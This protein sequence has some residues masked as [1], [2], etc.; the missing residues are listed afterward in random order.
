MFS[1]WGKVIFHHKLSS[2]STIFAVSIT[3]AIIIVLSQM[4]SGLLGSYEEIRLES[5][6]YD[7]AYSDLTGS[8][9]SI[10]REAVSSDAVEVRSMVLENRVGTYWDDLGLEVEWLEVEGDLDT[11]FGTSLVSGRMPQ[12]SDEVCITQTYLDQTGLDVRVGDVITASVFTD[13]R[14]TIEKQATVVGILDRYVSLSSS[15]CTLSA[16]ASVSSSAPSPA[17]SSSAASSSASAS[18]PTDKSNRTF[19]AYFLASQNAADYAD[20]DAAFNRMNY[21]LTGVTDFRALSSI[22]ITYTSTNTAGAQFFTKEESRMMLIPAILIISALFIIISVLFV[23]ILVGVMLT[24]RKRDYGIL[25]ALGLSRKRMKSLLLFEAAIFTAGSA[26]IGLPLGDGLL[27]LSYNILRRLTVTG[28]VSQSW[29]WIAAG[30]AILTVFGGVALAYALFY[31]TIFKNQ[32]YTYFEQSKDNATVVT[33]E[34]KASK[35]KGILFFAQKNLERNAG[36]TFGVLLVL[37][38]AS[39]MVMTSLCAVT[40]LSRGSEDYLTGLLG[41]VSSDFSLVSD[42][43]RE[44]YFSREMVEITEKLDGFEAIYPIWAAPVMVNGMPGIVSVY[45]AA[46]MNGAGLPVKDSPV[47]YA[48]DTAGI[49][50][51]GPYAFTPQQAVVLTSTD[52]TELVETNICDLT[53]YNMFY[54]EGFYGQEKLICN[55]AFA[56]AYLKDVPLICSTILIKTDLSYMALQKTLEANPLWTNGPTIRFQKHGMTQI[57]N[58]IKSVAAVTGLFGATLMLFVLICQINITHQL[59]MLRSKEYAVLQAVGYRKRD[60]SLIAAMEMTLIALIANVFAFIAAFLINNVMNKN[61]D[62]GGALL[63]CGLYAG[64]VILLTWLSS[65]LVCRSV[66]KKSMYERLCE[67]ER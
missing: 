45:T 33:N 20:M 7:W 5:S 12:S 25:L 56:K 31:A 52:G 11:I 65:Q 17:S 55:E 4:V 10:L 1:K 40:L 28:H 8:E 48:M 29:S 19:T 43:D 21:L 2:I 14:D 51:G 44:Q 61:T 30:L 41:S 23:R 35:G 49:I 36:R 18:D 38:A 53:S 32:P 54:G 27:Q 67:V 46:L 39:A 60:I 63:W 42:T 9:M 6:N 24:L 47:L 57:E 64:M 3:A 66:L 58:Q 37:F 16:S 50:S 15:Y 62:A 34:K 13:G 22:G 26:L 59:C